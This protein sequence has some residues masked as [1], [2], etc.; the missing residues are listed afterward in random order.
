MVLV[1]DRLGSFQV[2]PAFWSYGK[3]LRESRNGRNTISHVLT[4]LSAMSLFKQARNGRTMER[5]TSWVNPA[6]Q[7]LSPTMGDL[8]S[9]LQRRSTWRREIRWRCTHCR[10]ATTLPLPTRRVPMTTSTVPLPRGVSFTRPLRTVSELG[11]TMRAVV[12]GRP[13]L[14]SAVSSASDHSSIAGYGFTRHTDALTQLSA[15]GSGR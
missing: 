5:S 1:G 13:S 9:V 8:R 4:R 11:S 15:F 3:S 14:T 6:F 10:A 2:W 12:F 7:I